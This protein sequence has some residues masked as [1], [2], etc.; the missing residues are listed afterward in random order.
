MAI[1]NILATVPPNTPIETV[2]VGGAIE[3]VENLG[4]CCNEPAKIA[5]FGTVSGYLVVNSEEIL[6][7]QFG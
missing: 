7:V 5:T 2:N 4:G 1:E 6:S 3:T